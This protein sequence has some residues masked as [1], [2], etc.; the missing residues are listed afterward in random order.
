MKNVK[1]VSKT[2]TKKDEIV[3][4]NLQKFAKELENVNLKEKKVRETIY[5]YPEGF[6]KQKINSDEGKKFRNSLRNQLKR[7]CNNILVYAKTNQQDK[8]VAEIK[9]FSAF[10]KKNYQRNDFSITS[11]SS[12]KDESK[13]KDL[14]L[15]INIVKEF[16]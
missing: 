5:N 2:E 13:E 6:T 4:I 15:M 8:L 9:L 10:Y 1:T 3:K 14:T 16:K 11:L 12:S 7:I